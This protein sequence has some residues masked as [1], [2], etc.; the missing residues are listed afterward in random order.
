MRK[1]IFCVT[2]ALVLAGA[3]C[4]NKDTIYPV[5]GQV[6]YKG[7]P[8]SG[9]A[10]FFHRQGG[11]PIDEPTILGIVQADGSFE[12]VCGPLGKGAP[13][14]NYDVLIEWKR[15]TGPGKPRPQT[16][17]DRLKGRY[18]DPKRPLLHATVEA[19]ANH[20]PPFELTVAGRS[21]ADG[22]RR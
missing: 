3:S 18:A 17:P 20:L 1:V 22:L 7:A 11:D 10:V 2:A 15:V 19:R 9:A 6:T 4:S 16:G 21:Q 12:L 8:A 5:S 13:P 14:G